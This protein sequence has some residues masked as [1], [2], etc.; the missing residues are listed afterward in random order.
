MPCLYVESI[1]VN[2]FCDTVRSPPER[3]TAA[4][5]HLVRGFAGFPTQVPGRSDYPGGEVGRHVSGL[6]YDLYDR[7]K[8]VDGTVHEETLCEIHRPLGQ[9]CILF[10]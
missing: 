8:L 3:A 9:L 6:Q 10:E 7:T 4:G 2:L 5:S 1:T